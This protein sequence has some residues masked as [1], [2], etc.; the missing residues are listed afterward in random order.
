MR[1]DSALVFDDG[2]SAGM[3]PR[4]AGC[5]R[6]RRAF[7]TSLSSVD[8]LESM[9]QNLTRRAPVLKDNIPHNN[10]CRLTEK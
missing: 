2:S 7:N 3:M 5:V 1:D 9:N 8:T 4:V 10:S 6:K